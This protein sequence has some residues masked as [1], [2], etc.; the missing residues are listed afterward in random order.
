MHQPIYDIIPFAKRTVPARNNW[1]ELEEEL[2][3]R[4]HTV[5]AGHVHK[6]LKRVRHG[7]SYLQLA[8]TGGGSQMRGIE[9]GEFDHVVWVTLTDDGP[10]IANLLLDGIHDENVKVAN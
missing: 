5:F 1:P 7:R 2:I 9:E 6:Y 8:T 4:P 3:K 10:V